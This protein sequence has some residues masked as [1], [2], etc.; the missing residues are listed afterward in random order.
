M[1]KSHKLGLAAIVI[2]GSLV[3]TAFAGGIGE[4]GSIDD[5]VVTKSYVD[6]QIS[7][8]QFNN[9]GNTAQI[10]VEK[11]LAGDI[12]LGNSGTEIIVRTG[13]VVAFGDGSN[14]IPDVTSGEDIAIG[15]QVALNHQLIIPRSD[16][17]GIRVVEG[18][19]Y[20]MIRGT[21]EILQG[22]LENQ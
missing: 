19:S 7:Q 3:T 20:V 5:P 12:L 14:G 15:Q 11:L 22:D 13:K 2:A 18:T 21:Y 1:K 17:R 6:Q 10:V 8:L 4:P 9:S 16:G